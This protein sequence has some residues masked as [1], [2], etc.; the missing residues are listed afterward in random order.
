MIPWGQP[1]SR[2]RPYILP[3]LSKNPIKVILVSKGYK[4]E[5]FLCR[6]ATATH[7]NAPADTHTHTEARM[8]Q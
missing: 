6:S 1:S 3:F 8:L 2:S 7:T 4:P 5:I